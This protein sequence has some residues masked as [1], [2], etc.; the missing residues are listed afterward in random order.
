MMPQVEELKPVVEYVAS[1]I[2]TAGNSLPED[3]VE[4]IAYMLCPLFD[5][6]QTVDARCLASDNADPV[7]YDA[8]RDI[9]ARW[10]KAARSLRAHATW[11]LTHAESVKK[12]EIRIAA[13]DRVL[14]DYARGEAGERRLAERLQSQ[15]K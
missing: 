6:I 12:L 14:R 7:V 15:T 13:A 1:H 2:D 10:L 11:P 9:Y 3:A 5:E 8:L 4:G